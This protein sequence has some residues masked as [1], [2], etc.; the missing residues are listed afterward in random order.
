MTFLLSFFVHKGHVK[1]CSEFLCYFIELDDRIILA[2]CF[3]FNC[4]MN[5]RRRKFF[6]G[7]KLLFSNQNQ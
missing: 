5:L 4:K 2:G 3:D 1:I 7:G 6:S